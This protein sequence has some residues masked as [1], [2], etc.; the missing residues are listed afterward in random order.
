MQWIVIHCMFTMEEDTGE[1][2]AGIRELATGLVETHLFETTEDMYRSTYKQ[3]MITDV[4]RLTRLQMSNVFDDLDEDF[5]TDIC[6]DVVSGFYGTVLPERSVPS[7]GTPRACSGASRDAIKR[8]LDRLLQSPQPDQRTPEWYQSRYNMITASSA[9]KAFGSQSKVNEI[10]CA[11][12]APVDMHSGSAR[13]LNTDN[14]CHWG[15]KYEAVSVLYYEQMYQTKVTE[16]GCI[17]HAEYPFI[18]ASPDGIVVDEASPLYGRMLEIKNP[19]SRVINGIPKDEYWIQMQLQMEVCNLDQCDFLETKFS[20]YESL[21]AFEED[22][23]F[24]ES[25]TGNKKGVI[26]FFMNDGSYHYEYAEIGIPRDAFSV[27]EEEMMDKNQH[28]SWV[29]NVYWKLEDV[30]CVMVHRNPLWFQSVVGRMSSVWDTIL[31]EREDNTWKLRLPQPRRKKE[32]VNK[33]LASSASPST[34]SLIITLDI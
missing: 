12:C 26:M 5:V 17:P 23:D 29:T 21:E 19:F 13:G 30:S 11:K 2:A 28:M 10:I 33:V 3:D 15:I 32:A 16:F 18:G 14:A 1:I 9:H 8:N 25:M 4:M 6:T 7:V 27:W 24:V 20:E 31:K 22:G 34:P